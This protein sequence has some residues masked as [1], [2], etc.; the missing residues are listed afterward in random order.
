MEDEME[1]RETD[2]G[3]VVR[4]LA[5]ARIALF[6]ILWGLVLAFCLY[7]TIAFGLAGVWEAAHGR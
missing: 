4:R 5:R 1:P 6:L 2:I 3:R 7:A